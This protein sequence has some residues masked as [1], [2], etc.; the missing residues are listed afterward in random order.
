MKCWEK[1]LQKVRYNLFDGMNKKKIE[2]KTL[3]P[4]SKLYEIKIYIT[5]VLHRLSEAKIKIQ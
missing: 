1:D 2:G 3:Y 4:Q 5:I